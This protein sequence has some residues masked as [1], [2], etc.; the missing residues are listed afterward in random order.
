VFRE[1]AFAGKKH[2]VVAA[3][4]GLKLNNDNVFISLIGKKYIA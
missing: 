3:V 2:G 1:E 4:T